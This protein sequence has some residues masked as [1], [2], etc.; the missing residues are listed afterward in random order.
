MNERSYRSL[1]DLA[2]D[3]RSGERSATELVEESF[4]RIE[5]DNEK[6]TA[7]VELDR[8]SAH[9]AAIEIDR[10]VAAGEDPGPLA[11]IPFGVKDLED[12]MGMPTRGG[13]VTR[14]DAEPATS[15]SVMVARLR[16]AGGIPIGK[17]AV[18]EF[19]FDSATKSP[20]HGVTRNPWDLSRSPGGSSGGS[21]AAVSAGLVPFATGSDGGGSIRSPAAWCGLVGHKTSL[22]MIPFNE[23]SDLSTVGVLTHTVAD[24]ALALDLAAGPGPL[25]R[26]SLPARPWSLVVAAETFDVAG[27]RVAWSTDMG[28]AAVHAEV[29]ALA[30]SAADAL[31]EAAGLNEVEVPFCLPN[32]VVTWVRMVAFLMKGELELDGIYPDRVDELA[33]LTRR[34][35]DFAAEKPSELAEA[36]RTRREVELAAADLFSQVDVLLTPTTA[37]PPIGADQDGP[38]EI[39]GKDSSLTKAEPHMGMANMTWQPAVSVPAGLTA[40]GL[41]VGLQIVTRRFRDDVALRLGRILEQVRPW[42]LDPVVPT[43]CDH[44]GLGSAAGGDRG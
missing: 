34:G 44:M 17:T 23:P 10:R 40:D 22:G 32:A 37:C 38:L 2:E 36:Y 25:D 13:S 6:L 28:Y 24:T 35:L 26:T 1:R 15:D 39:E 33:S 41:P 7:F 8:E 21:A 16:G 9:Q 12:C 42:R 29:A 3:V 5:Q 31:V 30:R 43:V 11:G 19:G 4:A 18:P 20:L 27:L 14:K